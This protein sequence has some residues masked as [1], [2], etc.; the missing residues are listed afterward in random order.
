MSLND[1]PGED[2]RDERFE[3]TLRAFRPVAPRELALPRRAPGLLVFAAAAALLLI[4]S[5]VFHKSLH[6]N[7]GAGEIH[8]N[9]RPAGV[10]TA[11]RLN[12]ALRDGDSNLEQMLE[13]A[14]PQLLPRGQRGT[15]L[16]ELGKE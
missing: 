13:K 5:V 8:A 3:Q 9:P 11:G 12:S 16:F 1:P 7:D 14:G 15:A 10:V 4:A 2:S 6:R